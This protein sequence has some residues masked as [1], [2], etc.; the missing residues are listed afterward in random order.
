[1]ARKQSLGSAGRAS[2][3]DAENHR[4]P[5]ETRDDGDVGATV[6][7]AAQAAGSKSSSS[8]EDALQREAEFYKQIVDGA[9][10]VTTLIAPDGTMLYASSAVSM[11]QSLGYP[12]EEIIGRNSLDLVHPEDRRN[13]VRTIIKTL[14]DGRTEVEA[15][16]RR[17]DGSWVWAEMR[18]RAV[19][20]HDGRRAAVVYAHDV[21]ERRRLRDQLEKREAYYQALLRASSDLILVADPSGVIRFAS[22]SVHRAFGYRPEELL[23]KNVI[24]FV[25]P[26]DS[27]LFVERLRT[28]DTN[29]NAPCE[30]RVR[31]KDNGWID[32]EA[33]AA[34]AQGLDGAPVVV[35]SGRDIT[36]RKRAARER[37]MLAAIV[38]SSDDA[39]LS[40]DL[41]GKIT[42]W[43]RGAESVFGFSAKEAVGRE[44]FDLY[45]PP[46]VREF[47]RADMRAGIERI[48][49]QSAPFL[50][51][52]EGQAIRKDGTRVDIWIA[53]S[54]IYDSG[55]RLIGVSNIVRDITEHNRLRRQLEKSEAYHR[56][57]LNTSS[58]AIIVVDPSGVIR[59]ANR[60]SETMLGF[61]PEDLLGKSI[62]SFLREEDVPVVRE[63]L[64]SVETGSNASADFFVRRKDGVWIECE[65]AAAPAVGPDGESLLV[66]DARD[67]TERMRVERQQAM[68]AAIVQ[69]SDDAILSLDTEGRITSWNRGAKEIFGFSAE[70]ALGQDFFDL[71][72]PPEMREVVRD[73]MRAGVAKAR[74]IADFVH[75]VEGEAVC[76]DGRRITVWIVI[77]ALRDARG[78]LIGIA[79]IV[80][81]VTERNRKEQRLAMMASVLD[82]STDLIVAVDREGRVIS[83]NPAAERAFGVRQDQALGHRLRD[84]IPAEHLVQEREVLQR[85]LQTGEPVAYE[86]EQPSLNAT[87]LVSAF[88]IRDAS[89]SITG[90]AGIVHDIKPFKEAERE[91]REAHEYARGLFE[92]SVDAL[93]VVDAS[94]RIVDANEQFARLARLPRKDLLGSAFDSMFADPGPAREAI[95]KAIADGYAANVDLTIKC[96]NG[97]EIPVSFNA[98]LLYRAGKVY[99]VIGAARDVTEQR[100]AEQIVREER[101]Y[102]RSLVQSSPDGLLVCDSQLVLTDVN[103]RATELSGY[104]RQELIGISLPSLFTEPLAA[105]D[106]LGKARDQGHLGNIELRMLTKT[107]A[108][109]PVSL[110][111]SVMISGTNRRILIAVRDI[112]EQKRAEK[113]RSLLAAVVESSADAI[114]SEST[115]L[116][117]TSWNSAAER[118]FGYKSSEIVGRSA[119]LLAPLDRRAELVRHSRAVQKQRT[120]EVYE[121]K[122]VR[123]DGTVFDVSLTESPIIDSTG[124]VIALSVTARDISERKRMEA[125]LAKA[126][127]TALET[128]RLKSE[129][130][131]NMSHEIRTPLNSIVGLTGLLLDTELSPEQREYATDVRA[132]SDVLLSLIND[133][134]DF[135]KIAAGRI[136]L[137]EVD[138]DVNKTAED[139][140]DLISDQARGKG[141]EL[142]LAIDPDVPRLVRGDP[143]RLRQ[144][145]LNLLS[146]AVKF[147]KQGQIDVAVSKLG[148]NPQE[149]I[150]R[151]E[152]KDTGIGIPLERQHLLFQAFTQIDASTSRHYGGTGLGLSIARELVQAMQGTIGV[153]SKPGQGSTFWFTVKLGRQVGAQ[154]PVSPR[155]VALTNM[156]ILIVDDNA[157]SRR[158]LEG[159]TRAWGMQ[160]RSVGSAKE[161]LE[162]MQ[163]AFERYPIA[164]LDVMMP[165]TDGIELAHLIK[166]D[167]ALADTL[168]IFVSSVGSRTDF[169][170]RLANLD[171][172]DWLTKPVPESMLYDAIVRVLSRLA[173]PPASVTEAGKTAPGRF[174][175][176]PGVSARVLLAEDNPLNQKVA[177]LQL[178]KFGLEVDTVANGLEAL[179]AV[180]R[181]H[182]DLIFM[183]CQMPEMDGYEVTRE[184]RRREGSGPRSTIIAMTAH[185]LPG[186]REKCLAAG[187]DAY[188]SKPVTHEALNAVLAEVFAVQRTQ[189]GAAAPEPSP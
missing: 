93:V 32:C 167:P 133:I 156:R 92:S 123:R 147:T 70:E 135:S 170:E 95:R 39:I 111:V 119:A 37:T 132:S 154:R 136:V 99:G 189:P 120:P 35:L 14:K 152:V 34:S 62:F 28:V 188:V 163:R 142:T 33:V 76:K 174:H 56:T 54:G 149:A 160:P 181:H 159:Q 105:A 98:S 25:H 22:D 165:E 164:L 21:T 173:K 17:R 20:L 83:W 94:L 186:D 10:D 183:D 40:L 169:A 29:P 103:E 131:A 129:F 4:L 45:L 104:S 30:V 168:L 143:G 38:A 44:F 50:Y 78:S 96:I 36:E 109:I 128:A 118:L 85:I 113:E 75:R 16:V 115:D 140:L 77:T 51:R 15:R 66:I 127:D 116:V 178:S 144:I 5:E 162:V 42:S 172:G 124:A 18:G 150:L 9:A 19:T 46:E 11:P 6:S 12:L 157:V 88:P 146:N 13:V 122:R 87:F 80:R 108:T 134:L 71:Y 100:E 91:L 24:S 158:I 31:R 49:D 171:F 102:S 61:S 89:N 125:D 187:M 23:G 166:K 57:L 139:A 65:G 81:D 112:S 59:F 114:F 43:N 73:E 148:E 184:L 55:G 110:N 177:K 161:A 145:L 41:E 97:V 121:S 176:P 126:R 101:E 2:Q 137:E 74:E 138:F 117:V 182:Y 63:R 27:A 155:P 180:A 79:N 68:L 175:L 52:I 48:K 106:L 7:E 153:S 53:A 1:M 58:D 90:V 130:L 107:A 86:S 47:A 64:R 151:F 8:P 141:L 84:F 67:V 185:A 179:D 60:S 82:A 26:D 69:S 3:S 72:V